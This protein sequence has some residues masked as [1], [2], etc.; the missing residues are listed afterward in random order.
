MSAAE[1][2]PDHAGFGVA[3][4]QTLRRFYQT[5]NISFTFLSNDLVG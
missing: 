4:F 2:D 3:T 1:L 5:D